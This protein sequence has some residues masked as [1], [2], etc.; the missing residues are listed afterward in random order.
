MNVIAAAAKFRIIRR[1]F[2]AAL[3]DIGFSRIDENKLGAPAIL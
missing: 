2:G 1:A 3:S